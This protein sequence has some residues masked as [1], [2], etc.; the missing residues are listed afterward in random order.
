M[1][2]IRTTTD[3]KLV[4]LA[5]AP[6]K[7]HY[8]TPDSNTTTAGT[9]WLPNCGEQQLNFTQNIEVSAKSTYQNNFR[10]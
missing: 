6:Q 3:N 5:P 10:T 4:S 1:P 7:V 9:T 2:T 8:V